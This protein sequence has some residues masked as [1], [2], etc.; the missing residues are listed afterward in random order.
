MKKLVSKNIQIINPESKTNFNTITNTKKKYCLTDKRVSKNDKSDNTNIYNKFKMNTIDP[1]NNDF[2]NEIRLKTESNQIMN[3]RSFNLNIDNEKT[4]NMI[5]DKIKIK[6]NGKKSNKKHICIS[7]F[8][9][10]YKS[11]KSQENL[12]QDRLDKK[13][14]SLKLIKPEIKEQLKTKKRSMVG[15]Q[16]YL[17]FQKQFNSGFQNPFYESMKIKEELDFIK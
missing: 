1:Q 11:L 5:S 15:R 14:N 10:I 13:F 8:P 6:E 3:R 4:T 12:F 2:I 9:D 7:E 16:D 17:K